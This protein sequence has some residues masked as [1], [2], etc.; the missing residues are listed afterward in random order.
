ME[1]GRVAERNE[2][3]IDGPKHRLREGKRGGRKRAQEGLSEEGREQ[4]R[5]GAREQG[6]LQGRYPDEGTGQVH[7]REPGRSRVTI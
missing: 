7:N 3:G 1:G 2:R 6:K 5:K 4:G